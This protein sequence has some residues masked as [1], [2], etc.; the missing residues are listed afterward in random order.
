M[1]TPGFSS[2]WA[3]SSTCYI[4]L[5]VQYGVQQLGYPEGVPGTPENPASV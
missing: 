5:T 2:V 4:P 1:R 3:F